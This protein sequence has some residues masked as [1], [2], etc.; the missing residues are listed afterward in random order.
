MFVMTLS[1]ETEH[2]LA[3]QRDGFLHKTLKVGAAG[4]TKEGYF[5]SI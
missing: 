3:L 2:C 5:S 1:E 4:D